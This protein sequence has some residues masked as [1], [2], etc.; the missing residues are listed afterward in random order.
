MLSRTLWTFA[1]RP[2]VPPRRDDPASAVERGR[3]SGTEK[4]RSGARSRS[5]SSIPAISETSQ[6]CAASPAVDS[7]PTNFWNRS[8][9]ERDAPESAGETLRMQTK[10]R[11]RA[12]PFFSFRGWLDV[13][14][15]DTS[16]HITQMRRKCRN[17]RCVFQ[18]PDD[19]RKSPD[20][21]IYIPFEE[22]ATRV[23]PTAL[24]A[25]AL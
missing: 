7:A 12:L 19:F 4:T 2:P 22:S 23:L 15:L 18:K 6:C 3:W 16:S 1:V 9:A 14:I 5:V 8:R 24:P 20:I 21:Q 10:G 17:V 13:K 25:N 11:S